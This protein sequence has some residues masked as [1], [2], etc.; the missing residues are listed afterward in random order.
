MIFT[1]SD[2]PRE[3]DRRAFL[4]ARSAYLELLPE[5]SQALFS[6]WTSVATGADHS[7]GPTASEQLFQ[8]L[9]LECVCIDRSGSVDLMY[10][11]DVG[12]FTVR[13]DNGNVR[14]RAFDGGTFRRVDL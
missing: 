6:L 5:I 1:G 2:E 9:H 4:A 8:H 7:D 10:E 11:G 13:I 12:L 14:P 3:Q